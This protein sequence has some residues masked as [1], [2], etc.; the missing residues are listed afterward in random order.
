[1]NVKYIAMLWKNKTPVITLKL[2]LFLEAKAVTADLDE[3]LSINMECFTRNKLALIRI[4][5]HGPQN[6]QLYHK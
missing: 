2:W 1:M 3:P 4:P 5:A 6:S